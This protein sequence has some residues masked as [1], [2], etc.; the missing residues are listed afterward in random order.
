[1]QRRIEIMHDINDAYKLGMHDDIAGAIKMVPKILAS[2]AVNFVWVGLVEE[3][4]TGQFTDDRR[5][6]GSKALTFTAGMIA[7]SIVG[8]RD[9]SYDLTHG[10]ES[11]GLISTPIHHLQQFLRDVD[12]ANPLGRA[13]A[14]KLVQDFCSTLGDL[15]GA[16]PTHMGSIMRYGIDSFNGF[17]HPRSVGDV[18]RGLST[19][20]QKM[21]I[22][23]K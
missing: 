22:Q 3:L 14:G 6:L 8:L 5:G 16:C 15:S 20:T 9:L 10:Q 2:T 7:Q 19:G 11:I 13:H 1:M 4:I 17:Q 18:Y 12:K 21:R 23:R